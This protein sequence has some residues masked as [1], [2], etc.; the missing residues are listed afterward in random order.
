MGQQAST[1]KSFD[2]VLLCLRPRSLTNVS[3]DKDSELSSN[4]GVTSPLLLELT[5]LTRTTEGTRYV[6]SS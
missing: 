3:L 2:L 6:F 1:G 4:F 5:S